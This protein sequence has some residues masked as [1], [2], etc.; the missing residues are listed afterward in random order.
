MFFGTAQLVGG[1]HSKGSGHGV[2]RPGTKVYMLDQQLQIE[3][4]TNSQFGSRKD[5]INML[6]RLCTQVGYKHP[7]RF[8]SSVFKTYLIEK[9]FVEVN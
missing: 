7:A 2:H 8:A 4:E 3:L 9:K 1:A 5:V 6:T